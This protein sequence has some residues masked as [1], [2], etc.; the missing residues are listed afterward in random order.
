MFTR[1][2]MMGQVE[3]ICGSMFSGKTEE[4]IRR[5]RRARIARQRVQVFKPAVD[6][7]YGKEHV[8][9][10]T[11]DRVEAL[12]VHSA[13][14]LLKKVDDRTEVVGIDEVQF[15]D[16][17][18]VDVIDKLAN[19]GK[20]V[21]VAG[22][23]QD[24]LG[25]PFEPVPQIMAIAEHVTKTLAVCV[26]CGAPANRSQRL[27]S[28]DGRVLVGATEVYEPR[29]RRCFEPELARQLDLAMEPG[30]AV[31]KDEEPTP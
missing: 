22:L 8:T 15:F 13:E 10:H 14:E 25:R 6:D 26:R 3:V 29:C 2:A 20:R 5:L 17:A 9:S 12:V 21:I 28:G 19:R 31:A 27:V 16:A 23:D 1:Y 30:P 11:Q 7:R 18:I 4:L 24:Y